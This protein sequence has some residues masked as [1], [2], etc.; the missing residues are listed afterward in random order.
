[1]S[2]IYKKFAR[3][4]LTLLAVVSVA[5]FLPWN[6]SAYPGRAAYPT[7]PTKAHTTS[8]FSPSSSAPQ[9]EVVANQ[10]VDK[11]TGQPVTLH[12]VNRGGTEY[13][14]VTPDP[15]GLHHYQAFPD[16]NGPT[17]SEIAAMKSQW[18]INAVRIP[19]NQD[20]WLGTPEMPHG[21]V[22]GL[23]YR[24]EIT[25]YVKFL[26]QAGLV[27]ILDLSYSGPASELA[28]RQEPMPDASYSLQ[29]WTSVAQT[30]GG[31]DAVVFDAFSDPAP[32][33]N[34]A[35]GSYDSTS[36]TCWLKGQTYAGDP[37]NS[38]G[39]GCPDYYDGQNGATMVYACVGMQAVTQAIRTAKSP[40]PD[41]VIMLGGVNSG[42]EFNL[43][44]EYLP[45]DPNT[46]QAYTNLAISAH[47]FDGVTYD[48]SS[49]TEQIQNGYP[50]IAGEIG[51]G[52][53]TQLAYTADDFLLPTLA[54]LD[55]P[56]GDQSL[57]PQSYLA[58]H[59]NADQS[60]L[61]NTCQ[62][63]NMA[64]TTDNQSYQPSVCYGQA[65]QAY[66]IG[67]TPPSCP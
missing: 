54:Y 27:A 32:P 13:A 4:F 52:T 51:G 39:G 44:D 33:I 14:C 25:A 16:N 62:V 60:C 55:N 31:N 45:T 8:S 11:N 43:W 23:L 36:W 21:G 6:S 28:T 19:L 24:H 66:L 17:S 61:W 65:Y 30:F 47:I 40:A 48:Q 50:V 57:P 20:C 56:G 46:G 3:S 35:N 22:E 59:W 2:S 10:L 34:S 63:D 1:M 9:L 53:I 15:N 18:G 12:G 41:N 58:W 5:L 29:F 7:Y 67:N 26:N 42:N 38:C 49:L 37:S 64:L